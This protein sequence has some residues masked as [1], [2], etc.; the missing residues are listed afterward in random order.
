MLLRRIMR[1][2]AAWRA[3]EQVNSQFDRGCGTLR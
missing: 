2:Q 3:A 1:Y